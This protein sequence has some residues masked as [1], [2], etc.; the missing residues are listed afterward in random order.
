[1]TDLADSVHID[2]H[3]DALGDSGLRRS[4]PNSDDTSSETKCGLNA[5]V[6]E[7]G[8]MR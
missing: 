4:K 1:M 3:D 7:A 8:R 2:P 6:T 5:R